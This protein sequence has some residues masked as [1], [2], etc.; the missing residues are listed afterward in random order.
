MKDLNIL[1]KPASSA[2]NLQCGYCF[3]KDEIQYRE[4]E[5]YGIMKQ[6]VMEALIENAY[7]SAERS[8]LFGFQ[9]GEPA[10][11]GLEWFR[12]FVS[13]SEEKRK[14]GV[15]VTYTIQTNGTLLTEEWMDFLKEKNFLVGL[16]LDGTR[17]IHDRNRIDRMGGGTFQKVLEAGKEM[18]H[19]GIQVN[20]LTVLTRQ[21]ARKIRTIYE[22][23]KKEGFYYQ[24]YIPC[25]DPLEE[26][27]GRRPYSLRPKDYEYALKEL[28]DLW[29]QDL[30][31]GR[32][33]SIRQFENWMMVLS[34]GMPEACSMYGRCS[35]Q[36]VVE[37]NGDIYPCDFYVLDEYRMGNVMTD[38]FED[39]GR[40]AR[41]S[42]EAPFFREAQLRD[43]R[44]PTCRFYPLCRGGCRR[45]LLAE[46]ESR[47]NYY[48]EAYR[49]FFEY[50][51][52]RMEWLLDGR[53]GKEVET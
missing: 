35:M 29:F 38:T 19:R 37:A 24:Q 1:I 18:L 12:S 17:E 20:L 30:L 25:L 16:S 3:Y 45:D 44:C 7:A 13:M 28:F 21:A 40:K 52:E 33:V 36:N 42:Q 39:L 4:M 43:D 23:Y 14:P 9:G 8:C 15:S 48:C 50:S 31:K 53:E 51:I 32:S 47:R 41:D 5:N 34:G 22:F 10:M 2:C 6:E 11:A 49:A 26:L 46:G 27:P